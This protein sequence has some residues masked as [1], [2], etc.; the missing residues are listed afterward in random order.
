MRSPAL[1]TGIFALALAWT[2]GCG[3]RNLAGEWLNQGDQSR[4]SENYED[5][6]DDYTRAIQLDPKLAPAYVGRGTVFVITGR[7]EKGIADLTKAVQ[8]NPDDALPYE[9]RGYAR[10]GSHRLDEAIADYDTALGLETANGRVLKARGQAYFGKHDYAHALA[11]FSKALILR[12]NDPALLVDRGGAY[13]A[14]NDLDHALAD[15]DGAL[16]LDPEN[17]AGLY[18]RGRIDSQRERYSEAMQD[19]EK[20]I[21][22][23]PRA[24]GA[25]NLLAWLL[26]TCP[27]DHLRDGPRAVALATKACELSNW[28]HF[29]E[30]DTLAAACAETGDF[31]AAITYQKQAAAMDDLSIEFRTNVLA[32]LELYQQHQPYRKGGRIGD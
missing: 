14:T 19:F 6:I 20:V 27:D 29:A 18:N 13:L 12:T 24:Y 31:A 16:R 4:Q 30:V 2:V 23:K 9:M 21:K 28:K 8:L 10:Y 7:F 32:R 15:Y 26:A 3:N 17:I 11:D 1:I 22:L 25:Y 5:A